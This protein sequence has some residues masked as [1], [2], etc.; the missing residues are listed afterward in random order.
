MYHPGR[1]AL[2]HP[3]PAEG[4]RGVRHRVAAFQQVAAAVAR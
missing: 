4:E 2:F 3:D 1:Q